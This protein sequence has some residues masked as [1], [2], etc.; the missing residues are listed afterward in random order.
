MNKTL[1]SYL[2]TAFFATNSLA[3]TM[4]P[5]L[6][7]SEDSWVATLSG[8]PSWASAGETQTFYLAPQIIKTYVAQKSSHVLATGEFFLG[9][10]K[11]LFNQWIA[12]LGFEGA[13]TNRTTLQGI[14]WDDA[15][16][17]F[18]NY[19]YQYKVQHGRVAAKGKLLLDK[20]TGSRP[21]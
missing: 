11:N 18:D 20:V 14:I 2:I 3:G 8:G 7:R 21:G 16:P 9:I 4:G 5:V 12:Q 13:I 15:D 19:S 10:Q 17:L 1:L 6:E